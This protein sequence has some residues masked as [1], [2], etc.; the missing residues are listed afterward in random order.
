MDTNRKI[1]KSRDDLYQMYKNGG[2]YAHG[3]IAMYIDIAGVASHQEIM[4]FYEMPKRT[5]YKALKRLKTSNDKALFQS[6][7]SPRRGSLFGL[8]GF[9]HGLIY[10]IV[11]IKRFVARPGVTIANIMFPQPHEVHEEMWNPDTRNW[12]MVV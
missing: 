3:A 4:E 5:F 12:E 1:Y 7:Y 2:Y 11:P 6:R 8:Y 9:E 10:L